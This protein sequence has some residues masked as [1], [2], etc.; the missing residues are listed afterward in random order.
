M[1]AYLQRIAIEQTPEWRRQASSP[2]SP[3]ASGLQILAKDSEYAIT[4]DV[5][6]QLPLDDLEAMH[7]R[8]GRS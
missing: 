5:L 8:V 3:D 6:S 7:N 1:D 2:T 4:E